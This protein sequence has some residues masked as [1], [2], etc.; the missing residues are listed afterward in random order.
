MKSLLILPFLP[1]IILG[2]IAGIVSAGLV[3]GWSLAG[4]FV[5]WFFE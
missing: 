5:E 2:F 3:M 1:F 4:S